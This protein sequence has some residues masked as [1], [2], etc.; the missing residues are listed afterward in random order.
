MET[1]DYS[2]W[3]MRLRQEIAGRRLPLGG[4]LELTRRCNN[5]CAHCYNNLP[6][7]DAAARAAELGKED[8]HR[9]LDEAAATGCLYLLLTGGEPLLHPG[10]AAIYE[11]ARRRGLLVTVFTNGRGLTAETVD[12]L[13]AI[14]PL[15]VEVTLYGAT[16]DTWERVTGVPGSYAQSLAGIER[17]GKRGLPLRLKTTI[18]RVN[19]HELPGMRRLASSFGAPFRFDALLNA[20]LD[21]SR[22]PLS[23]RLSPE[24]AVALDLADPERVRA[25]REAKLRPTPAAC[26]IYA[27]GAG[28]HAFAVDPYGRLRLCA[29]AAEGGG[30]DLRRGT[31]REGWEEWADRERARPAGAATRCS[32]CGLLDLCGA[33]PQAARLECGKESA[34]VEFLCEV[35]HLRALALGVRVPAHGAC[36]FCPG[37][38]RHEEISARAEALRKTLPAAAT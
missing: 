28:F 20:R 38:A 31:F 15:A 9:L 6:A 16:R 3:G 34:P 24:E 4:T 23:L 13:A 29:L 12:L 18:S 14:P 33:C 21:G 10:F 25:L 35:A 32:A 27:C 1:L 5:R 37:G 2:A 17:L 8:W 19:S 36:D 26:G 30:F 22:G 7:E 11:H